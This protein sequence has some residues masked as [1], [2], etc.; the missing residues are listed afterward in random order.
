M[1]ILRQ[2][3]PFGRGLLAAVL[4]VLVLAV[5]LDFTGDFW[6][7]HPMLA[8]VLSGTSLL[9]VAAVLVEAI[10]AEQS[11]RRWRSVAAFALDDLA[12][13]AREVWLNL[14]AP[15]DDRRF[16][17]RP[18]SELRARW[19]PI[20]GQKELHAR[21]SALLSD[22][23]GGDLYNRLHTMGG[24]TSDVLAR[25]A[26]LTAA[27]GM[28]TTEIDRFANLHRRI[29]TTLRARQYQKAGLESPFKTPPPKALTEIA[30]DAM[31]LEAAL[32]ETA[33]DLAPPNDRAPSTLP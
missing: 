16:E 21:F 33:N 30:V 24:R 14:T 15:V 1:K 4:F 17:P 19:L 22:E 3:S 8:E 7:T 23:R 12:R 6:V 28:H 26:P 32:T 5:L 2:L 25:W 20:E 29:V 31:N 10:L 18:V 27:Q 11:A 13:V 9:L